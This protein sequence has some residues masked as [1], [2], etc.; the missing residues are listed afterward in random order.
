MLR[1]SRRTRSTDSPHRE[2]VSRVV[3]TADTS[4]KDEAAVPRL[5]IAADLARALRVGGGGRLADLQ[6]EEGGADY[7]FACFL[8]V[9]GV[10]RSELA[11]MRKDD[12][13][14]EGGS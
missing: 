14:E 4:G 2:I 1:H 13:D 12:L 11:R 10:R 5:R 6:A 3:R 7:W 9:T 8:L